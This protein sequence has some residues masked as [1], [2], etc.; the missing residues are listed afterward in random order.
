MSIQKCHFLSENK[1]IILKKTTLYIT[2]RFNKPYLPELEAIKES[3][4]AFHPE[5]NQIG[6]IGTAD[7][8]STLPSKSEGFK[9]VSKKLPPEV[10]IIGSSNC[11]KS[12]FIKNLFRFQIRDRQ[13]PISSEEAGETKNLKFYQLEDYLTVVDTPGF[14]LNQPKTVNSLLIPYLENRENL[15]HVIFLIA[16]HQKDASMETFTENHVKVLSLLKKF[17]PKSYSI[18]LT[19]IDSVNNSTRVKTVYR[20]FFSTTI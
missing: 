9:K 11:G 3:D 2:S 4:F 16:M 15:K 18:V 10:A 13:V 6:Y 12:T 1:R 19:K 14:G 20:V 5:V 17:R 8:L 7:T